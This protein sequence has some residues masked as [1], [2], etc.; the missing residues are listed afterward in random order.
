MQ[1]CLLSLTDFSVKLSITLC[2]VRQTYYD[3]GLEIPNKNQNMIL[4]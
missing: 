4:F 2:T 3:V 1:K